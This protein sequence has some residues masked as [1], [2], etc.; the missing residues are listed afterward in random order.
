MN[1]K[2]QRPQT[3]RQISKIKGF[4]LIEL[5]IYVVIMSSFT[6]GAVLFA[7]D[8]SY[9][10]VKSSIHQELNH[11]IRFATKR[12]AFEIRNT[13][14]IN[15]ITSTSISLA[16]SDSARNPTIIDLSGGR[17]RIGFGSSGSCPTTSPCSLTSDDVS[18]T[19]LA[20]TNLSSGSSININFS[21]SGET[22]G[23]RP[24]YQASQ[25]IEGSGEIRSN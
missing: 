23:D 9:A 16:M 12:I 2:Y 7:W 5:I 10:R 17:V 20:F 1:R 4:T 15:S 22:S 13:Q 6:M 21:I 25:T 8:I 3:K 14:S 24:E 19:N 11:N 18:I